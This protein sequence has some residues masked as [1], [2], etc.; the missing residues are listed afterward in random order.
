MRLNKRQKD[1]LL[2]LGYLP[3]DLPQIEYDARYIKCKDKNGKRISK[4]TVMENVGEEY[5]LASLGRATFHVYSTTSDGKYNMRLDYRK[6]WNV[7]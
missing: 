2:K 7:Q 6:A 3:E 1:I 5:F 4:R